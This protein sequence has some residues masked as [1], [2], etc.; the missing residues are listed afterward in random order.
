MLTNSLNYFTYN[1][2]LY[3]YIVWKAALFCLEK[4]I[5]YASS[6]ILRFGFGFKFPSLFTEELLFIYL[7]NTLLDTAIFFCSNGMVHWEAPG[8]FKV[9]HKENSCEFS[10]VVFFFFFCE[11][12]ICFIWIWRVWLIIYFLPQTCSFSSLRHWENLAH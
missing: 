9:L 1:V 12:I 8:L 6:Y 2:G 4:H 10:T 7:S 11:Y 5:V 3:S